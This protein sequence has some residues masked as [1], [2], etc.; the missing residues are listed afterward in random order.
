G[1]RF[2]EMEVWALYAYGAANVL[3]EILT[4]KSDDTNG[5]VKTYESIVKGE[6]VPS[7][8]I[9]ESFKVLVKEI[10]SLALDIEPI[11]YKRRPE[12]VEQEAAEEAASAVDV[13]ADMADAAGDGEAAVSAADDL[14]TALVGDATSD[15]E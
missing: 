12:R 8:G 1:Q 3:Q 11:S 9:P 6:N 10:R 7:A 2:G 4:V 5:R 13:F 14:E 15:K